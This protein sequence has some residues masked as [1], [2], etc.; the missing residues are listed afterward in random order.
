LRENRQAVSPRALHAADR[1]LTADLIGD[2]DGDFP[3]FDAEGARLYPGRWNARRLR[4]NKDQA[5]GCGS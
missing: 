5:V 3:I 1:V 4:D 2:P